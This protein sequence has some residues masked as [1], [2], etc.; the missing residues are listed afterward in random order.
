MELFSNL[1]RIGL[2]FAIFCGVFAAC[3]RQKRPSESEP[4]PVSNEFASGIPFRTDEP[5][6]YQAEIVVTTDGTERVTSVARDREKR[7]IE[8]DSGSPKRLVM[9]QAAGSF[10]ILP[11]Q[12][13][14][15]ETTDA[16]SGGASEWTD[17]LTTEALSR[18]LVPAFEKLGS[19]NGRTRYRAKIEES[20]AGEIVI[21]VD[22]ATGLP[23][24]QEYFSSAGGDPKP[25]MTV[26][27]RNLKMA[28]NAA[29]FAVP[30]GFRKVPSAELQKELEK[31]DE[32]D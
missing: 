2:F 13:I 8:F 23:V 22:D 18:K 7:R 11:E 21:T 12:R 17:F 15:S 5:E 4:A 24:R 30:A 16:K 19:E 25:V 14:Y 20:T 26:E 1:T 10:L 32:R 9:L 31:L 3:D 28:A 27:I 29:L 6:T